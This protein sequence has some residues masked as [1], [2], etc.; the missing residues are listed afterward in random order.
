MWKNARQ[1]E[2]NKMETKTVSH[3]ESQAKAQL[4]SITEM[5]SALDTNNEKKRE[6][7]KQRIQEDALEVSV[8]SGWHTPGKTGDDAQY[9]I[10]LCTGDPVV[11]IIGDLTSYSEPETA[12]I[13]HQDW[14]TP[15]KEYSLTAEEEETV[16]TYARQ[17][18]FG[19]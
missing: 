16:L 18:Y 19:N 4:E 15:W 6:D 8:R 17:F 10:L 9:L 3:S 7:A 13:E 2:D 5:V 12:T 1:Q 14:G 11:R